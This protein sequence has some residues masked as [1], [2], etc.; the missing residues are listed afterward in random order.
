MDSNSRF[1]TIPAVKMLLDKWLGITST[2]FAKA[3][4]GNWFDKYGFFLLFERNPFFS[5]VLFTFAPTTPPNGAAPVYS[6]LE[7]AKCFLEGVVGK[8][9]LYHPDLDSRQA[10]GPWNQGR[11]CL[12]S[13]LPIDAQIK[14]W[15]D[16]VFS[17]KIGCAVCKH[18]QMHVYDGDGNYRIWL[19][20]AK[21]D[22]ETRMKQ[23][24]EEYDIFEEAMI[25]SAL[26]ESNED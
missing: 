13:S 14:I 17:G 1:V 24:L 18:R 7:E 8:D 5:D 20:K 11:G 22:G 3:R 12:L 16:V 6:V 4:I 9:K 10:G 15:R 2:M 19:S 25:A 26:D 23:L 21:V